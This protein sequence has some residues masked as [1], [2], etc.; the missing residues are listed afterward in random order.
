MGGCP[1]WFNLKCPPAVPIRSGRRG[2]P[3]DRNPR[4]H[5]APASAASPSVI[6]VCRAFRNSAPPGGSAR[7]K[8]VSFWRATSAASARSRSTGPSSAS[9]EFIAQ[10]VTTGNADRIVWTDGC[11]IRRAANNC[12]RWAGDQ[13]LRIERLRVGG[14]I[15]ARARGLDPRHVGEIGQFGG[16]REAG[17]EIR[18]VVAVGHHEL[19]ARRVPA[20]KDARHAREEFRRRRSARSREIAFAAKRSARRPRCCDRRRSA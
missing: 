5:C 20:D 16:R 6:P 3:R 19:R 14:V 4:M 18:K 2:W 13:L 7:T 9:P 12:V 8:T 10:I 17:E 15:G 11:R 1:G